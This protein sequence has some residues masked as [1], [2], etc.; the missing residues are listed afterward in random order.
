MDNATEQSAF[1]SGG[2]GYLTAPWYGLVTILGYLF[3]DRV[4]IYVYGFQQF[5]AFSGFMGMVLFVKYSYW[6]VFWPFLMYGC[7]L[8]KIFR[9]YEQEQILL[10]NGISCFGS[11]LNSKQ[12][13]N[14][15]KRNSHPEIQDKHSRKVALKP[16]RRTLT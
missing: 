6:V 5:F 8:Q 2:G 7:D 12:L 16:V 10:Y 15:D 13:A 9:I 3:H 1:I 14:A 11:H 4:Q